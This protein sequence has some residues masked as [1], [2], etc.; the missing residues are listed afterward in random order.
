M[1]N[2]SKAFKRA[3]YNNERNYLVYADITL[4]DNTVLNLTNSEIWTGGFSYE[5]A[6]SEDNNFTALG[7][8]IIGSAQLIIN[9]IYETY[10]NY[11]FTN[12][13][14]VLSIGM[15]ITEE[16]PS[17]LE[18]LRVGTYT[19]DETSYNGATIRLSLLDNIEQFDRPYSQST[20]R[21][22]ATLDT[23]LRDLCSVCGVR[24]NTYTFPHSDHIIQTRP[25][26]ESTTCREV[27][28]WLAI[29]AGCFV[30]CNP[31]GEI[32]LKWFNVA[33]LETY[34]TDLDGG[35]F[36][37]W[38]GG[39]EY[40]GGT[41]N[42]WTDGEVQ[43]GGS[44]TTE[45]RVHYIANLYSQNIGMD[46]VVITGVSANVKDES[47]ES[48]GRSILTFSS[49]TSGYIIGIGENPFITKETAQ[50]IVDDLGVQ[51]IGL[52]FRK[53]TV[54]TTTDP[55][56]DVGDVALVI[57]R[58]QCVYRVLITRNNFSADGAQTIVCGAETPSRNQASKFSAIT[59]SYVETR[60][61]LNEQRTAYDEALGAL[62]EALE[63]K[64]GLYSTIEASQSGSIY[65]L[66]DKPVLAESKVVW[67]M[68][69]EAVGVTTNYNG[70]DPDSTVWNFGVQINGDVLARILTAI[71]INANWIN[72]GQI[73]IKDTRNN[74]TFFADTET[75]VV[76]I[77]ASSFS[78]NGRSVDDIAQANS[79]QYATCS[80]SGNT[81]TKT[82]NSTQS[83]FALH[84]GT[85]ISVYFSY[86]NI[87]SN[88][89]LNVNNTGA[90]PIYVRGSAI[91]AKD[92]WTAGSLVDFVYN[93]SQWVMEASSQTEIYNRLTGGSNQE[94]IYLE[95][96]RLYIN[97]SC[98]RTGTLSADFIKGGTLT[99]GGS[100]N[101][102]GLLKIL[103]SS[104]VETGRWSN[105]GINMNNGRFAV[106]A[107]GNV[108]AMS[109]TAYGSLICYE[110]YT[111]S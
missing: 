53:L 107:N 101:V 6:V 60:K 85:K 34:E 51:L 99:L 82:I 55:S 46:D 43:D 78:L 26:D 83:D 84:T 45:N 61:L 17:R 4:T 88:P 16:T 41:F 80:T 77:V 89:T 106:D 94:G 37:P 97:A 48:G 44:F 18:T 90:K 111:I 66:H 54:T 23:I 7:S 12:A 29:I 21:Y 108:T 30:K 110:S 79:V 86:G 109:L 11:D 71:G 49:G 92:Y 52:R 42:P 5:E 40:N 81:A 24:L 87:A 20:L 69:S 70:S 103:N 93:G 19:V 15:A 32:E 10:S 39:T 56:I 9:N 36:N 27:L 73:V 96:G 14:V 35:T 59:K 100:N 8:V 68:N 72:A 95:N 65:Y 104:G 63:A 22:P 102:N 64:S 58:K 50:S 76:R 1:K 105:A 91:T 2:L 33:D 3:L 57:D 98:I 38:S 67:K 47:K 62:S 13:K 31:K 74:E 28:S 25:D 75:G